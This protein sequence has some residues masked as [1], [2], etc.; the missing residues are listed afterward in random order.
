MSVEATVDFGGLAAGAYVAHLRLPPA[1][2]QQLND[3]AR[4]LEKK[5]SVD[6]QNEDGETALMKASSNGRKEVA[7]LLLEKKASVDLQN[8]DGATALMIAN[9]R[10]HKELAA[11]LQAAAQKVASRSVRGSVAA[12]G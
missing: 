9:R 6:M 10:G 8:K 3:A 5:A 12:L 4:L 1:L 11:M 2:A 7:A